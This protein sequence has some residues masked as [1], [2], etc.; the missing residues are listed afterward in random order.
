MI[1]HLVNLSG[2]GTWRAPA[3]EAIRVGPLQVSI[4]LPSGVSGRAVELLVADQ[5]QSVA[6]SGGWASFELESIGSHEVVVLA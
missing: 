5:V 2:S 6:V 1:L 4:K 3:R